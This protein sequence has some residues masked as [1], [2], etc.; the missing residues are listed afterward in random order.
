MPHLSSRAEELT[1]EHLVAGADRRFYA[2]VVDR[3]FAWGICGG[4]AYVAYTTLIEPGRLWTG[5]A[6]IAGTVLM[7]GLLTSM[8]VGLF[9]L[10]P[11]RPWSA[12]GCCPSRTPGRSAIWRAIAAHLLTRAGDAADAR[13]RRRRARLDRDGR[14]ERLAAGLARPAHRHRRGRRTPAAGG[15]GARGGGAAPG[16]QPHRDAAGAGLADAAAPGP[17]PRQ[18]T[19]RTSARGRPGA[20]D[21]DGHAAA[22]AGL[23][24]GRG[25]ADPRPGAR[26]GPRRAR[27]GARA[28]AGA[29]TTPDAPPRRPP[30][31]RPSAA[32]PAAGRPRRRRCAGRWPSTPASSSRCAA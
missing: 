15:R 18:A 32:A 4:E 16:R 24:A 17:D 19:G 12:S 26:T 9:G 5:V 21:A 10:T 29:R 8:M 25:G 28:G 14:P 7:V 2:F 23:A 27:T 22:G 31:A 20:G 30:P 11:A 3:L 13:L 1:T 6:A